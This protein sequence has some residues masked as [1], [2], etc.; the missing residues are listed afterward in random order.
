MRQCGEEDSDGRPTEE[1]KRRGR[2]EGEVETFRSLLIVRI[3]PVT[4][5]TTHLVYRKERGA[6]EV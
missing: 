3:T 6:E 2:L 4:D 5:Q 1:G